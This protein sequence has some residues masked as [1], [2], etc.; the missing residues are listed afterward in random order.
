MKE[1][2]LTKE[3]IELVDLLHVLG[4]ASTGGQCRVL[5]KEGRVK[6]NGEVEMRVRKKIRDGDVVESGEEKIEVKS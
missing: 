6:V 3:Y 4:L 2:R 5:I 1:F